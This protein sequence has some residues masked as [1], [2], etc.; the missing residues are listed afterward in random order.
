MVKQSGVQRGIQ[1][2]SLVIGKQ[3]CYYHNTPNLNF[4][5]NVRN[6]FCASGG[7]LREKD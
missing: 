1:Y 2:V 3:I 6:A 5:N 7:A 4:Q